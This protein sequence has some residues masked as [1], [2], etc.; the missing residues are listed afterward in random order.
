MNESCFS[1]SLVIKTC[2]TH[3]KSALKKGGSKK[4]E[5]TGCE[6]QGKQDIIILI[7]TLL[8]GLCNTDSTDKTDTMLKIS[9]LQRYRKT[10]INTKKRFVTNQ[11]KFCY[12]YLKQDRRQWRQEVDSLYVFL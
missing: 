2:I 10:H 3:K 6:S 11:S 8:C 12:P 4:G 5:R 7:L 9:S 1:N